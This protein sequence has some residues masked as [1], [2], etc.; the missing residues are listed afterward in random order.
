MRAGMTTLPRA[1]A[2][3]AKP[4]P[5][6][7]FPHSEPRRSEQRE[8]A[9]APD[10]VMTAGA[11]PPQPAEQSRRHRSNR[12]QQPGRRHRSHRHHCS[13]GHHGDGTIH[14]RTSRR[15]GSHGRRRRC[16]RWPQRGPHSYRT[17]RR[18]CSHGHDHGRRRTNRQTGLRHHGSRRGHDQFPPPQLAATTGRHPGSHR[19]HHA[20]HVQPHP[21]HRSTPSSLQ[22]CTFE[23]LRP[24][25]VR[26]PR[27]VRG[28]KFGQRYSLTRTRSPACG[29]IRR[30]TLRPN[31]GKW[32]TKLVQFVKANRLWWMVKLVKLIVNSKMG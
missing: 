31:I 6:S 29:S 23:F 11:P 30:P 5:T 3:A 14:H 4:G 28:N 2:G 18:R 25:H 9:R 17:L 21:H 16:N 26:L 10:G 22:R 13:H 8:P 27:N 1:T 19:N 7:S 12:R 20:V 32:G 15:R 24:L